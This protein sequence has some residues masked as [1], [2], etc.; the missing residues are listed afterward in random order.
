MDINAKELET[1]LR[2]A[3]EAINKGV[4]GAGKFRINDP[5]EFDLAVTNI[6]A[7]G[8][9]L[10]IYIA[11]AKAEFK[12]EQISRIRIKVHPDRRSKFKVFDKAS[13]PPPQYDLR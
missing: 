7:S 11:N 13:P 10:K 8:G 12:S 2:S 3:L 9:G 4:E 5:I 6:E 1:Y